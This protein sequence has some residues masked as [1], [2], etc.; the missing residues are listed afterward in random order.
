MGS[1]FD[2]VRDLARALPS[3]EGGSTGTPALKVKGKLLAW[4]RDDPDVLAVKVSPINREYLLRVEPEIFFLTDHYR[5]YPI[6][7][8]RLSR[9]GRRELAEVL[10]EAWRL[11]APKRMRAAFDAQ[12]LPRS[13][14][15]A[16]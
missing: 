16:T 10:E 14:R 9:I 5:D 6:V 2:T 3:V 12:P 1:T 15:R 11:V 4:L 8:I 7:L 13:K